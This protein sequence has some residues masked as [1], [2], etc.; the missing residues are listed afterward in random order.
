MRI[1]PWIISCCLLPFVAA[2]LYGARPSTVV[3]A[4]ANGNDTSWDVQL[5]EMNYLIMKTSS[6]N[7]IRGLHLSKNQAIQLKVLADSVAKV[8]P[9]IPDSKGKCDNSLKPTRTAFTKLIKKLEIGED[10]SDSLKKEV[11]AAR[12]LE[13]ELI[14]LSLIGAQQ[15]LYE[16]E[17]CLQC[18]AIPARYKQF[19]G[20]GLEPKTV[21]PAVRIET[22]RAHIYG[23]LGEEASALLWMLKDEVISILSNS[24]QSVLKDFRCCLMPSTSLS[25]PERIGQAASNGDWESYLIE[26]RTL[27]ESAWENYKPLYLYPIEEIMRATLPGIRKKEIEK[28]IDAVSVIIT[29]ARALN[30]MDFE[31]QKEDLCERLR[32][33]ISSETL[34]GEAFRSSDERNFLSAL[35]LLYF[36]SSNIYKQLISSY[37]N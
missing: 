23:V 20:A 1:R 33:A 19:N 14:K 10:I 30:R 2:L 13:A 26:I 27:S 28:R 36:G 29:E 24:Q 16:E 4:R 22:D 21:T 15:P 6:V 17:G 8:L 32:K 35:F 11:Y 7:L 25:G 37:E 3:E 34:S 12:Q 5:N 31:L 9:E 18:H